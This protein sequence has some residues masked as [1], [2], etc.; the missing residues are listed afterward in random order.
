MHPVAALAAVVLLTLVRGGAPTLTAISAAELRQHLM[1]ASPGTTILVAPGTYGGVYAVGVRGDADGPVVVRPANPGDPPILAEGMQ[2]SEAAHLVL[3]G[4]VIA[5]AAGNGL[6]IDDGGTPESPSHHVTLRGLVVR[7]CGGRGNHD[8]IKLSGVDDFRLEGCTVERWGRGG[9]AVDM[10]GCHRGTIERCVFRDQESDPAAS[11]VQAKGGSADIV[12]RRCRFE[13]AGQRAVNIGGSTGH[14]FFRPT[15]SEAA[16]AAAGQR[17]SIAE[18]RDMLVEECTFIGSAAPIAFVGADGAVVRR[19]TIFRP[20][21]WV[22][23]ILQESRGPAF[24]PCRNG[25][26][27]GNIVVYRIGAIRSPVNIGPDT[28]A[29]TFRFADNHWFAEDDPPRSRP[30]LPVPEVDGQAGADPGFVDAAAGDLR[31]RDDSPARGRGV[32]PQ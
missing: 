28:A 23:R 3:E 6:N 27:V 26:F 4:L 2:I 31:L 25:A 14:A 19:N 8:G 13:H 7:D 30:V 15:L 1:D 16:L 10:V 18:V 32:P 5:G 9:S 29:E 12:V 20:S 24:V 11:G 21:A 17:P 22:L